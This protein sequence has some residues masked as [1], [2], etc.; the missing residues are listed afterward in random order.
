MK[1]SG[2]ISKAFWPPN[3]ASITS[4]RN[5]SFKGGRPIQV[6]A[7]ADCY[8]DNK[9][10]RWHI[11]GVRGV[12]VFLGSDIDRFLTRKL[13]WVRSKKI[14]LYFKFTPITK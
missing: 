2:V 3:S 4:A 13:G 10:W 12:N 9:I 8:A 7:D 6:W 5:F 14:K 1:V 11:R